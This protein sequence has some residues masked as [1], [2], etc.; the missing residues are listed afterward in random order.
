M[1]LDLVI[2]NINNMEF[3]EPSLLETFSYLLLSLD[4]TDTMQIEQLKELYFKKIKIDEIIDMLLET[5]DGEHK[6]IKIPRAIKSI[7]TISV[8]TDNLNHLCEWIKTSSKLDLQIKALVMQDIY[9]ELQ[10]NS[11]F[12]R[13]YRDRFHRDFIDFQLE[14][15]KNINAAGFKKFRLKDIWFVNQDINSLKDLLNIFNQENFPSQDVKFSFIEFLNSANLHK[16]VIR[17][18]PL[19]KDNIKIINQFNHLIHPDIIN[20]MPIENISDILKLKID[21]CISNIDLN[22]DTIRSLDTETLDKYLQRISSELLLG[23]HPS[24]F[25]ILHEIPHSVFTED[26]IKKY[27]RFLY[28]L[29]PVYFIR[30]YL[31]N[32][33]HFK[34]MIK[35]LEECV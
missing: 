25:G 35:I 8:I 19:S 12:Y 15:F 24:F 34:T 30:D 28:S 22:S 31:Q 2:E 4:K 7:F 9:N 10:S 23:Y 16:G 3:I 14:M 27:F 11:F 17:Y 33:F 18:I 32:R 5:K 1:R 20:K 21:Y 6:F 13:A 29:Q 26:L